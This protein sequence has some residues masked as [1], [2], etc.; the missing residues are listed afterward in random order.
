MALVVMLEAA[1]AV[2]YT[3]HQVTVRKDIRV[4]HD[5]PHLQTFANDRRHIKGNGDGSTADPT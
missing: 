5:G 2:T 4:V 3:S 1:C